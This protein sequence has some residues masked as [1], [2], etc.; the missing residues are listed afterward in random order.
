MS[1]RLSILRAVHPGRDPMPSRY[2]RLT[3]EQLAVLV[4]ELLLVGH[5]IDRAGMPFCLEAW[6]QDQMAEIAVEEWAGAS[7]IYTKRMQRAL[8]F[9]GDDVPTIFKGLRLGLGAA[10]PV[11]VF[12]YHVT[13]ARAGAAHRA[14]WRTQHD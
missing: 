14:H 3:R 6:G 11:A 10:P 13:A 12:L 2:D 4:P 7:P 1:D 5:L 9:E 8:K